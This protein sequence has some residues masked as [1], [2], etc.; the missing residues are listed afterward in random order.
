[1]KK[2]R[3]LWQK[4]KWLIK[5][6]VIF[7]FGST[8][9]AVVIFKFV[10]VPAT[11]LMV[12]RLA[13]QITSDKPVVWEKDWV[14]IDEISPNMWQ[15]VIAGEDQ[16]FMEHY[17]FDFESMQKAFKHNKK[18]K[19]IRGGSTVSQQTAKNVF[20]WPKRSYVR[21]AFEAYFTALIEMIWGKERIMEVYL[22]IVELGNGIYGCEAAAQHYFKKPASKLTKAEAAMIAGMLPSPLKSNP[23]NPNG[24]LIRRR[25]HILQQ[26]GYFPQIDLKGNNNPTM[27]KPKKK[28]S[29][30][31]KK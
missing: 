16:R 1:M 30:K 14:S 15:A 8:L 10:P 24:S 13:E 6:S 19:K 12:I 9:L 20:L 18:G 28:K 4:I 5:W 11:P 31:K 23:K 22:N 29:S 27:E 2:K 7:F 25:D 3:T 21:K 17:G 26:M